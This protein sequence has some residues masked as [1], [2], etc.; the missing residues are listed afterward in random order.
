[1]LLRLSEIGLQ[2]WALHQIIETLFWEISIGPFG[3]KIPN[4]F[5]KTVLQ[6][7]SNITIVT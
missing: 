3:P 4:I 7:M 2:G 1:M 5:E 6:C